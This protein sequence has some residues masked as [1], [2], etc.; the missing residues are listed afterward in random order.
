MSKGKEKPIEALITEQIELKRE[1]KREKKRM[2]SIAN[3]I[4]WLWIW[5]IFRIFFTL[6]LL[7]FGIV[8]Y[9]LVGWNYYNN[10]DWLIA[11]LDYL[12][13]PVFAFEG[14]YLVFY[15]IFGRGGIRRRLRPLY[16]MAYATEQLTEQSRFDESKF[17]DLEHAIDKISPMRPDAKLVT[18]NSDLQG[19]EN[20]VNNLMDRMRENYRQQSRF[21]SDA[22]HEL[23]TPISVIQGYVNMLDRWG[24]EDEKV[25][26]ESIE[27]IKSESEHMKRM[28]EQ[29]LFLARGD[30]GK[31]QL[32]PS[33]FS[34]NRLMREVYDEYVM[35]ESDHEF[36][37]KLP[38][39]EVYAV[40]DESMIKQTARILVDNAVK[41][42]PPGEKIVLRTGKNKEV[43]YFSVQ[44]SG[45]GINTDD[46][47]HVFE[48]FYRSDS[49]RTRGTGGTGLGLSIA[50]W[51]IDKHDGYF[52]LFSREE[53]GTRISVFLPRH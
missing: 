11:E 38:E 53:L 48:R 30:S 8:G 45:V 44:D 31:T 37:L 47:P 24:A 22:S 34:L 5:R 43:P 25:L 29:L 12:Y 21:V 40:A 50:K 3:R 1:K 42:S 2:G 4:N 19:L 28:V 14:A 49:S 17:H 51:I 39:D 41:Y 20:A 7:V 46:I 23:R 18:G 32:Q 26:T 35:I 9:K 6:D 36:V 10:F 13:I 52:E 16:K 33:I 15:M 27:A